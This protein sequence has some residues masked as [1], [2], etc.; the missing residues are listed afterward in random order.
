MY[1]VF[2]IFFW[3]GSAMLKIRL[4]RV[5]RMHEPSFRLV[6]TDSKNST[7]SGRFQEVLGFYDPRKSTESFKTERIK[8]VISQGALLT[9]SVHNLLIKHKVIAGKK[10][11]VSKNAKVKAEAAQ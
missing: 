10:I 7:K 3:Y 4:Q 2:T 6:L 11:N 9:P 1:L 8:S 5:G